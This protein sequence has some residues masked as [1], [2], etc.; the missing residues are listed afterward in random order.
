[1]GN[2]RFRCCCDVSFES[3]LQGIWENW[4]VIYSEKYYSPFFDLRNGVIPPV[5]TW[6]KAEFEVN[7]PDDNSD[8]YYPSGVFIEGWKDNR[9]R[10]SYPFNTVQPK[11]GG[12]S[13]GAVGGFHYSGTIGWRHTVS[14][15]ILPRVEY[16]TFSQLWDGGFIFDYE[17][18]LVGRMVHTITKGTL[19][20]G[21]EVYRPSPTG[22]RWQRELPAGGTISDLSTTKPNS[23]FPSVALDRLSFRKAENR[24]D[25]QLSITEYSKTYDPSAIK[26]NIRWEGDASVP[27]EGY[28]DTIYSQ[29]PEQINDRYYYDLKWQDMLQAVCNKRAE[30]GELKYV[31]LTAE[32][33]WDPL[34]ITDED[35]NNADWF[36]GGLITRSPPSLFAESLNYLS[37]NELYQMEGGDN[38][39][40]TKLETGTG[41]TWAVNYEVS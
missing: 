2:R 28:F 1:M 25:N 6:E 14:C 4:L 18:S 23:P 30:I 33:S 34:P 37:V 32:P 5:S 3:S 26:F 11:P 15:T 13:I 21:H 10:F 38:F 29:S 24:Y 12:F 19:W 7:Y 31:T 20:F 27:V 17:N 8:R 41:Q 35:V 22:A 40:G 9:F 39:I 36:R 16:G